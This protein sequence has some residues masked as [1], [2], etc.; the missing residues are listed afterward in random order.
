MNAPLLALR[1]F[2]AEF[3]HLSAPCVSVSVVFPERPE[4][5][6]H[7]DLAG[8]EAWRAALGIAPES[9]NH[10]EQG[11][12]TRVLSVDAIYAGTELHLVGFARIAP[13]L[14]EGAA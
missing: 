3:A 7:D 4:L 5:F 8:F 2:S 1:L 13:S 10:D 6:F 9:V 11:D 12:H 14:V